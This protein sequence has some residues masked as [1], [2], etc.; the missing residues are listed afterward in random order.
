MEEFE[1]QC[2]ENLER[3]PTF[4]IYTSAEGEKEWR[5]LLHEAAVKHANSLEIKEEVKELKKPIKIGI[6]NRAIELNSK[7]KTK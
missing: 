7:L 3:P 2:K 5:R 6:T 4:I 1:R